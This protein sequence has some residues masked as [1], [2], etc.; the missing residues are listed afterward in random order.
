MSLH[1]DSRFRSFPFRL[2]IVHTLAILPIH[3]FNIFFVLRD[4]LVHTFPGAITMAAAAAALATIITTTIPITTTTANTT[5]TNITI[6]TAV[7][8]VAVTTATAAAAS[9]ACPLNI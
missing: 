6:S 1:T 2:D 5:T 7:A 9:S 4:P 3:D 8:A